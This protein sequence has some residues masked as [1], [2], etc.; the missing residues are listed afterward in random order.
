MPRVITDDHEEEAL[1]TAMSVPSYSMDE[2]VQS[3]KRMPT[4]LDPEAECMIYQNFGGVSVASSTNTNDHSDQ[5][6]KEHFEDEYDTHDDDDS[7]STKNS[8]DDVSH[9]WNEYLILFIGLGFVGFWYASV[10]MAS[11][12][13][14]T[15]SSSNIDDIDAVDEK[16]IIVLSKTE[17]L[18]ELYNISNPDL[19]STRKTPQNKALSWILSN[20]QIFNSTK[21]LSQ[22]YVLAVFYYSLSSPK[23]KQSTWLSSTSH[24]TWN[25]IECS[26]IN[27]MIQSIELPSFSLKGA[28]P[29]EISSLS[30]LQTLNLAEN[31]ISG[32]F[33]SNV[34][35]I[36]KLQYLN[37]SLN[38][39]SGY[40][41]TTFHKM[42]SLKYLDISKNILE[43]YI[44]DSI[45]NIPRLKY[46]CLNSNLFSGILPLSFSNLEYLEVV[47][48]NDNSITGNL[49]SRTF[50][51][52]LPN[53][54]SLIISNN[55]FF[56]SLPD[57]LPKK[58]PKL[59]KL[60]I[61]NNAFDGIVPNSYVKFQDLEELTLEGNMLSG[62][63]PL[64]LCN[65]SSLSLLTAECG[66]GNKSKISCG[67]CT[68]CYNSNND[69]ID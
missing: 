42:T 57:D 46:L 20:N 14:P 36:D 48:L 28:I 30:F 52:R 17:I 9:L 19:I 53:F 49:E 8:I 31:Q 15:T 38:T 18:E 55:E 63:I 22:Y 47:H 3:S 5:N 7:I 54:I 64:G 13:E 59:Q 37:L 67:C 10:L 41:P 68:T 40:L 62:T 66:D 26:N 11:E 33:P 34:T 25:G 29:N 32:S 23:W 50:S 2:S 43:G 39:L 12:Y 16:D 35:S 21:L 27:G 45:S 65:I 24:C 1:H 51:N 56:G 4:S 69:S 58:F 44:H 6:T 61:D 60:K